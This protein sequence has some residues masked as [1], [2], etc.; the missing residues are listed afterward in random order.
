[1]PGVISIG[2]AIR[3]HTRG[4]VGSISASTPTMR[5]NDKHLALMREQ[6]LE[7]ARAM[8][9]EFGYAASQ[10]QFERASVAAG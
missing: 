4:I 1:M 9:T 3:D 5:A 10:N 8:S 2:A 7:A 6:V